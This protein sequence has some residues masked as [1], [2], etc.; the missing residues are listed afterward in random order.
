MS[1][2]RFRRL[3][4]ALAASS[5]WL[6]SSPAQSCEFF[7]A[8]FTVIHPW[9]EATNPGVTDAPVYF[10]VEAVT[11]A[12]RLVSVHTP[13]AQSVELR[14]GDDLKAPA[15]A[16]LDLPVR[17]AVGFEAGEPH[18]MLR[19]LKTPLQWGRSYEMTLTFEKAGPVAVMVSVGA[20]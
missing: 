17:D 2:P 18:L 13:I 9:A 14:A 12:D 16:A 7:T 1:L 10:K 5:A 20:H 8:G 6:L 15:A 4:L 3:S 19:G 11:V